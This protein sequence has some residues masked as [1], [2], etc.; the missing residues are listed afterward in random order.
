MDRD[1]TPLIVQS[2]LSLLLETD[3]PLYPEVRDAIA[4][5][6]EMVKCPEHV[7]TYKITPLSLWNAAAAG[8][9]AREVVSRLHAHS[10]YPVM[11]SLVARITDVMSRYG[12]IRLLPHDATRHRLTVENPAWL[13]RFR[14][15][16]AAGRI[17]TP[18]FSFLR[19]RA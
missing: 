13:Q 19:S 15:D 6:A 7:H 1:L 14:N 17:S 10:R 4:P 9:G 12:R 16:P 18:S 11:D 2:D 8:L 5:F 3:S